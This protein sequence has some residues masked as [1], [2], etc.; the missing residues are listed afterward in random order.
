M[1]LYNIFNGYNPSSA[2]LLNLLQLSPGDFG[3]YRDIY[4]T[5]GFIVVH[6]RCGGGNRDEYQGVFDRATEHPWYDHDEDCDFDCTYA[7]I[8][9]KIPEGEVQTIVALLGNH[10]TPGEAWELFK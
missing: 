3:R 1:S 9:F 6:T 4:S 8:F 2:Q 5:D 7:D 10:T